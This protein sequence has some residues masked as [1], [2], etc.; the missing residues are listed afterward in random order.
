MRYEPPPSKQCPY[1]WDLHSADRRLGQSAF[2]LTYI[3]KGTFRFSDGDELYVPTVLDCTDT[4]RS[5]VVEPVTFLTFS[6]FVVAG[7]KR[8]KEIADWSKSPQYGADRYKAV[9]SMV[10]RTHWKTGDL[11]SLIEAKPN[12]KRTNKHYEEII[13][14][15]KEVKRAYVD[16]WTR[17]RA[18]L[19]MVPQLDITVGNL[20][21]RMNPDV[22]MRTPDGD[23]ALKVRFGKDKLSRRRN[24]VCYFLYGELEKD[25]SW[26]GWGMSVWD[27][28]NEA[29]YLPPTRQMLDDI[30]GDVRAAI[31]DFKRLT[32]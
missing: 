4:S 2:S 29:I 12:V 31:M 25:S 1:C 24:A 8:R 10:Q 3:P 28:L 13:A 32:E 30:E 22:G 16:F 26:P 21:I 17:R 14:R 5:N 7:S 23:Q 20:P 27:V 19:F 18:S 9:K 15:A 6:S 11:N